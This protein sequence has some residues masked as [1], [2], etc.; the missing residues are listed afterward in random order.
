MWYNMHWAYPVTLVY[1]AHSANRVPRIDRTAWAMKRTPLRKHSKNSI[2]V[3]KKKAWTV[4][5]RYIR[6]R[7]HYI[8]ITCGKNLQGSRALHAGHYISRRF[9][10]TL[11]DPRNVHAQC[12]FCN[13]FKAG[14]IGVYTLKLQQKYGDDIIKELTKKSLEIKQFTEKELLDII[15]KYAVPSL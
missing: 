1:R 8:C 9:N 11:F 2:S 12:M 15:A 13:M 6:A 5:S 3:L 10:A 4:F 14:N 7:D